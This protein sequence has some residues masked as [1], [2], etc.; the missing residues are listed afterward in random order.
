[1]ARV[2]AV[3]VQILL[4]ITRVAVQVG[5]SVMYLSPYRLFIKGSGDT[6]IYHLTQ[7]SL[8]SSD[9]LQKP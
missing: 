2:F 6:L 7:C 8:N 3:M 5:L 1:M 9:T 4:I